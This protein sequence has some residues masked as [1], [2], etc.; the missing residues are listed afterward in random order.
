V[1]HVQKLEWMNG[2]YIRA[3]PAAELLDRLTPVLTA[4]GLTDTER[5]AA[6]RPWMERVVE[7]LRE[8]LRRLNDAVD[9]GAFYFTDRFEY[10][11]K[12]V[13]KHF[14]RPGVDADLALLARELGQMSP[15]DFTAERAEAVLRT[16]SESLG[17]KPAELIHPLRLA[18]TGLTLG[19]GLF[20]IVGLLGR[21]AC[22][23][24]IE[25]AVEFVHGGCGQ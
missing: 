15:A 10:D 24:R 6:N 21:D 13:Q 18:L 9:L 25:R 16:L 17:C 7:T 1:F 8:R 22:V 23:A 2:E 14:T 19:P 20:E 3:L 11:P 5:I 12:D 4:A